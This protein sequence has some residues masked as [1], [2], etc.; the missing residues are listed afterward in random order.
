[1]T[2]IP[3]GDG[4]GYRIGDTVVL[5]V[6]AEQDL[7]EY[8][9]YTVE[10]PPMQASRLLSR[11]DRVN[12]WQRQDEALGSANFHEIDGHW[13]HVDNEADDDLT[14]CDV[15]DPDALAHVDGEHIKVYDDVLYFVAYYGD[16][17]I[18]SDP[19]YRKDLEALLATTQAAK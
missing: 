14:P 2:R 16:I 19:V 3:F 6:H 5:D 9:C 17:T 10:I 8:L 11:M 13:V 1:M 7:G 15:N 4:E 12:E 18:E